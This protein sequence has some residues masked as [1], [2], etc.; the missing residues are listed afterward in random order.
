MIN[1][2]EFNFED[3]K[4]Y[5]GGYFKDMQNSYLLNYKEESKLHRFLVIFITSLVLNGSIF[6]LITLI[7]YNTLIIEMDTIMPLFYKLLFCMSWVV[8]FNIVRTV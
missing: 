8:V 5:N 3:E 7:I 4:Y 2:I 1:N 6:S